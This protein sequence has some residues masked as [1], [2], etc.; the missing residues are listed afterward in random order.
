[1]PQR[2][3]K[4]ERNIH[5][6][7]AFHAGRS[8]TPEPSASSAVAAPSGVAACDQ[9]LGGLPESHQDDERDHRDRGAH[10]VDEPR[11]VVVAHDELHDR[12]ARA[13]DEAGR[14]DLDHAA[15]ADLRGDEPE[16]DD[17]R[18]ER[19][20]PADH[21]AELVQIEPG[22]RRQRDERNAERA[23][24][25]RRGVADQRELGGFER[26]EAEADQHRAADRHRR[27]E[28][29]GALDEG[30]EANAISSAWM[31]RSREMPAICCC[32][33]TNCP[34]STESW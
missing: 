3:T 23:E 19:Q 10:D 6:S 9:L 11:A 13:G 21:R 17:E 12:E 33:T 20:L 34:V 8:A 14:P 29:G 15:P 25:D 2:N 22:D 32:R 1:M 26:L 18:E 27:A 16:R 24:G 31:R 28:A 4:T 30:A 7:H 5:G